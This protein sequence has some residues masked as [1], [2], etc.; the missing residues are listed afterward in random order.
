MTMMTMMGARLSMLRMLSNKPRIS[1]SLNGGW[2]CAG[3]GGF[4]DGI[5]VAFGLTPQDAYWNWKRE[6]YGRHNYDWLGRRKSELFWA[7]PGGV[8]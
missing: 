8:L 5:K 7:K 4:K 2:M 3:H 1:K 6:V